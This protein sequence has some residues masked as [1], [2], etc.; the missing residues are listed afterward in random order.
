MLFLKLLS[1]FFDVPSL[2]RG[3]RIRPSPVFRTA[4]I[5]M[6]LDGK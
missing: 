2:P 5:A 6:L 1:L 3:R 4:R